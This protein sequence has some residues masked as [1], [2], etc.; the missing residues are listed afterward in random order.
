MARKSLTQVLAEAAVAFPDNI[1]ELITPAILRAWI[2]DFVAAIRPAYGVLSI[3]SSNQAVTATPQALAMN[4]AQLSPVIDY[5]LTPATGTIVRSEPGM[6]RFTVSADV[7]AATAQTVTFVLYKNG[8]ATAWKQSARTTGA[9]IVEAVSF[10]AMEYSNALATYQLRIS[11][12]SV[13]TVTL[14]DVIF[15]AET[16]PVWDYT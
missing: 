8:V 3:A 16:V 2:G 15:L 9:A 4:I 11:S 12:T 5:V 7:A 6:V 14:T 13:G 1:T 10:P